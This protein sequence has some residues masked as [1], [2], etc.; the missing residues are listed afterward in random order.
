MSA[1]LFAYIDPG[2]GSLLLQALV[3]AGFSL[4]VFC[5]SLLLA[6]FAVLF[7]GRG[8]PP[9]GEESHSEGDRTDA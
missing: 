4:M 6:P 2:A 3:A 1:D 9:A 8:V 7:K 5:R